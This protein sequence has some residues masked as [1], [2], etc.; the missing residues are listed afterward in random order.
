MNVIAN[1]QHAQARVSDIKLIIEHIVGLARAK[2][3]YGHII[4][5]III[6]S[7]HRIV[8]HV[9]LWDLYVGLHLQ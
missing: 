8:A 7:T 5:I 3:C 2:I 4:I 1:I 6:S 9:N